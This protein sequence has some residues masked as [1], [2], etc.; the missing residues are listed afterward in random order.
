MVTD[1]KYYI[2]NGMT[3]EQ[4]SEALEKE[5]KTIGFQMTHDTYKK[6]AN[7]V[8]EKIIK[9]YTGMSNYLNT[10]KSVENGVLF[11]KDVKKHVNR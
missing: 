1:F 6:I 8:I 5:I 7:Y 11:W 10:N 9:E 3:P 2:G 4:Q